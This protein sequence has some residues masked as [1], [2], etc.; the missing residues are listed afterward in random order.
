MAHLGL[1]MA[2]L[3]IAR[4]GHPV[5]RQDAQPVSDLA[6]SE[7]DRLIGDMS[8]TMHAA[9]GV[10]LAAPQVLAGVRVVLFR[11]PADRAGSDGEAVPDTVLINPELT[12]L[13]DRMA[14]GWEGCLSVPGLRG[15]V[16][17]HTRIGYRGLAPDGS[18]VEGEATG[19]LARVLQHE[20][21]HLDGILY[22]DRMH[23]LR[24]L[25][26][27]DEVDSFRFE[28]YIESDKNA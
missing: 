13:D 14:V 25:V 16:P 6:L 2:I 19:F 21:D 23:D 26:H 24:L 22:I 4:I 3:K 27:E 28:D 11:V 17:R 8:E 10:G 5:L 1:A 7:L 18:R 15:L 20:V 12:A 9:P